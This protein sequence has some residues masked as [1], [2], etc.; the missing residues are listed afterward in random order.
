AVF[1]QPEIGTVGLSEED[2]IRY[3][4]RVEIYRTQ[5]R[6][7]RNTLSGNAEK[8][9]MKLIVDGESRI[10]IGAHILGEGAGEM[11]QLVGVALKGKLTKDVFDETMAIHPTAAE[12]LVTMYKPS[13]IYENG[14]KLES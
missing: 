8:M 12:E 6:S 5:F 7:L 13:Y 14:K 2:A 4:E 10:V 11:A 3:Y 9:F 1:S